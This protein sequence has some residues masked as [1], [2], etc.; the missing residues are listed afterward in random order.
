M[1][2]YKSPSCLLN[3]MKTWPT[4]RW[5]LEHRSVQGGIEPLRIKS[6]QAY[7]FLMKLNL[8]SCVLPNF[9]SLLI[10]LIRKVI[11]NSTIFFPNSIVGEYREKVELDC[12]GDM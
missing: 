3:Q 11:N 10:Y 9:G 4:T 8:I 2:Q 7:N 12:K 1:K 6:H 5:E